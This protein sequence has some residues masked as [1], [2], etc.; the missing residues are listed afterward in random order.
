MR[1]TS[2]LPIWKEWGCTWPGGYWLW[3][4]ELVKRRSVVRPNIEHMH[5][6][7]YK[8]DNCHYKA[9]GKPSGTKFNEQEASMRPQRVVRV[10]CSA[11]IFINI[12]RQHWPLSNFQSYERR[13]HD[14]AVE[15]DHLNSVSHEIVLEELPYRKVLSRRRKKRLRTVINA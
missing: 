8:K 9:V 1:E 4:F 3:R 15:P 13:L 6:W 7:H 12:R 10:T 11:W 5:I 2:S 14:T